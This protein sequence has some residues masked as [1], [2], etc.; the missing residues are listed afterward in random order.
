MMVVVVKE[1]IVTVEGDSDGDGSDGGG[2][3]LGHHCHQS[4]YMYM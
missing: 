3:L 2:V 4:Y 1:A